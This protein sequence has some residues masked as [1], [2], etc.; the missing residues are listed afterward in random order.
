MTIICQNINWKYYND[1]IDRVHMGIREY[2]LKVDT[3][4]QSPF[5]I[6][7]EILHHLQQTPSPEGFKR[8][9]SMF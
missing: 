2:D 4:H 9:V 3:T 1:Q 8:M 5:K 7:K 6:A